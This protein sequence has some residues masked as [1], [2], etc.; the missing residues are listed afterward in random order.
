MKY[1]PDKHH[2]RSVRLQGYDYAKPGAYFIT[3]C[4]HNR[5][6]L[7]GKIVDGKMELNEFGM[8]V[9]NEWLR[10]S[11]IRPN[12]DI[13][14]F[15]I[16]PN[17]LH[18]ILIIVDNNHCRG[19]WPYAPTMPYAPTTPYAPA[20]ETEITPSTNKPN[21]TS[22]FKSPSQ[23]IGA[24]IR[25]FKSATTKQINVCR[26]SPGTPVWQRNY[27][28]HIIRNDDELNRI[29]AYIK[30][31]PVNWPQDKN[32]VNKCHSFIFRPFLH[33]TGRHPATKFLPPKNKIKTRIPHNGSGK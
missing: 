33:P 30:N 20:S 2:R 17:H 21:Q 29:R 19:V 12:I 1:N 23:T 24:I 8:I 14:E 9:K 31:N 32:N 4:A 6:C 27:Y 16:M 25:G 5:T 10:T 26:N 28:E 15:V 11:I 3:I 18:G 13:D 7:F 22:E